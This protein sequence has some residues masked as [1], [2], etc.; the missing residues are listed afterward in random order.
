MCPQF[1]LCYTA[2]DEV[3]ENVGVR[4]AY[5]FM[6]KFIGYHQVRIEKEDRI[7]TTFTTEWGLFSYV[8][9]PSGLKNAPTIFSSI[10]VATFKKIMHKFLE[11]Y[12]DDQTIFRLLKDHIQVLRLILYRCRQSQISLNL[13]KCI[14]HMPFGVLLDHVVCKESMIVDQVKIDVIM[15]ISPPTLVKTLCATLGHIG[16]YRNFIRNY[17]QITEPLEKLLRK[18]A[19]YVWT[20][21][22]QENY[23]LLKEKLIMVPILVFPYWTRI[24]YVHVDA[25]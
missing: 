4:E 10:V 11:V 13:K 24:F 6:D 1:H 17:T 23:D 21:D 25:S 9:M 22:C 2:Y 19:K 18:D 16:F 14:F 20:Q 3:M 12:L 7:N 5:S 8:V 15:D